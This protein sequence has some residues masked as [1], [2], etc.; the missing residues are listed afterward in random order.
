MLKDLLKIDKLISNSLK[1]WISTPLM[2]YINYVKRSQFLKIKFQ[3]DILIL[4]QFA[5]K[6]Q[7]LDDVFDYY[8]KEQIFNF[9]KNK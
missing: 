3:S 5:R 7:L 9:F 8:N 6:C 2:A 1:D 4:E